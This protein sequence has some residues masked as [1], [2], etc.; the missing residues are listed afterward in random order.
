MLNVGGAIWWGYALVVVMHQLS[1]YVKLSSD[2]FQVLGLPERFFQRV[3][4]GS[5]GN[6]ILY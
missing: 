3:R 1:D 6:N 2:M 5:E 4:S